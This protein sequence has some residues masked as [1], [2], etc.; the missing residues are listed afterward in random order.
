METRWQSQTALFQ[1]SPSSGQIIYPSLDTYTHIDHHLEGIYV[2]ENFNLIVTK[3]DHFWTVGLVV[4]FCA[5]IEIA[6]HLR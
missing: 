1:I 3:F 2:Y 4:T 5:R 6:V